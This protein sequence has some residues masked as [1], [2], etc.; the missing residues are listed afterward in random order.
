[1]LFGE[2][3]RFSTAA[4]RSGEYA[5]SSSY[6]A[7]L[8]NRGKIER[9]TT[10]LTQGERAGWPQ[11]ARSGPMSGDQPTWEA[12]A[13]RAVSGSSLHVRVSRRVKEEPDIGSARFQ[14]LTTT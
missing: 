9:R 3:I 10:S 6:P 1:M 2:S 14:N 7:H 4:F 13:D 5:K 11:P 12:H 8:R